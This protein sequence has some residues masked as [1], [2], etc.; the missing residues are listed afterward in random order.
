M[1]SITQ[2]PS[3]RRIETQ[4]F[5]S[6]GQVSFVYRYRAQECLYAFLDNKVVL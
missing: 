4:Y 2:V 3:L 6:T 5:H 1:L